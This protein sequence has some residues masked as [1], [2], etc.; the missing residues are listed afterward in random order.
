MI[1]ILA[2]CGLCLVPLTCRA[3][4]VDREIVRQYECARRDMAVRH[5][6]ERAAFDAWR[7]EV[8]HTLKGLPT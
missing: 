2:I 3:W 6:R 1:A 4:T 8:E 5:A 7:I